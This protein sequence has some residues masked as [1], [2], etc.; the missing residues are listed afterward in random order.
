MRCKPL[1]PQL[2]LAHAPGVAYTTFLCVFVCLGILLAVFLRACGNPAVAGSGLALQFFYGYYP[3]NP[4]PAPNPNSY[5]NH[6]RNPNPEPNPAVAGSGLAL[7]FFCGGLSVGNAGH[8]PVGMMQCCCSPQC[9]S[10]L[11]R[12]LMPMHPDVSFV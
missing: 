11:K 8:T 4:N 6:N 1:P 5:P 9:R 3:V 10:W 2:S 12:S 7:Q